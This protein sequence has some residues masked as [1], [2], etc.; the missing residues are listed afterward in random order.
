MNAAI[1][2]VSRRLVESGAEDI[3]PPVGVRP[4][5]LHLPPLAR[6][7]STECAL[8]PRAVRLA[9]TLTRTHLTVLGWTGDVDTAVLVVSE[10]VTNAVR[11]ACVPGRVAWLRLALLEG[12]DLLVD[13]SDPVAGFRRG[14]G[15]DL[16][17][18]DGDEGGRGLHLLRQLGELTWFLR[19][20]AVPEDGKTV[21]VRLVVGPLS[22]DRGPS[23]NS[24][25]RR[26]G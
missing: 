25:N 19:G 11:H 8:T 22:A 26:S 20:G 7:W 12:G 18:T 17:P 15:M 21:R 23:K 16:P 4:S 14:D 24:G 10:L 1:P 13:V 2:N 6:S 3:D 9:R 5:M